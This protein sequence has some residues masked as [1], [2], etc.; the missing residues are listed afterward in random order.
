[1]TSKILS[2]EE[3]CETIQPISKELLTDAQALL[4]IDEGT[5]MLELLRKNGYREYLKRTSGSNEIY[6][7]EKS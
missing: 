7:M 6:T 4:G 5:L 3:F 1:M 2:Y